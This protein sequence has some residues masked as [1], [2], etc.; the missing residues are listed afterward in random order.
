MEIAIIA[1]LLCIVGTLFALALCK[2]SAR[3]QSEE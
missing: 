3:N 1:A 2:A